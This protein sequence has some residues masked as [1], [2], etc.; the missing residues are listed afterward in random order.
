MCLYD[1]AQTILHWTL[2]KSDHLRPFYFVVAG[3]ITDKYIITLENS[4][5][6]AVNN[7][8]LQL[9]NTYNNK[10]PPKNARA[11]CFKSRK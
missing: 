8:P 4:L 6:L 10:D 5:A 2:K 9:R 1:A 7:L 3:R 11:S